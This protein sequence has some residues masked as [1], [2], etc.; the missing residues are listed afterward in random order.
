MR[1]LA[2]D[3][4]AAMYFTCTGL[5][6]LIAGSEVLNNDFQFGELWMNFAWSQGYLRRLPS[7]ARVVIGRPSRTTSFIA[8]D[9]E[10]RCR[11]RD[12]TKQMIERFVEKRSKVLAAGGDGGRR[13][14]VMA[15]RVRRRGDKGAASSRQKWMHR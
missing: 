3:D 7:P 11:W 2:V 14:P 13:R 15:A 9:G 6:D 8:G 10:D 4:I 12:P 5:R 1:R